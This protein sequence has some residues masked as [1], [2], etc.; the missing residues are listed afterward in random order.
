M[1][2]AKLQECVNIRHIKLLDKETR[3]N[4]LLNNL[5]GARHMVLCEDARF[6]QSQQRTRR[7]KTDKTQPAS[8][9]YHMLF[10]P[11]KFIHFFS[12]KTSYHRC[13]IDSCHP[14]E[15]WS[16]HHS[17]CISCSALAARGYR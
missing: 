6:T 7:M 9:K 15:Q 4:F 5:W 3:T 13:L 11:L 2:L 10:F 12:V 14:D 8:N 1:L 17:L 16:C